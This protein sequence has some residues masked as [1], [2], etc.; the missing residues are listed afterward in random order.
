MI[1]GSSSKLINSIKIIIHNDFE[2]TEL[3]KVYYIL[4][5]EIS[6]TLQDISLYQQMYLLR[7]FQQ[8]GV[9]DSYSVITPL[10]NNSQLQK[11]QPQ[12]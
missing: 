11:G 12:N 2:C 10:D 5:I 8:F 4:R 1:T 6:I 3:D 9:P 7:N